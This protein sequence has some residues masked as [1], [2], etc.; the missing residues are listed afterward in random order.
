MNR[1]AARG[2]APKRRR[3]PNAYGLFATVGIVLVGALGGLMYAY[4]PL[5]PIFIYLAALTI[6]AFLLCGYDKKVAG[7][8]ATRV[9]E[10][11]L[12]AI[13]LLG[14]SAG[15]LIG[16]K[17]FRHKTRKVSFRIVVGVIL[18]LQ[19]VAVGWLVSRQL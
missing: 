11:V 14:G 15:L 19:A 13:A 10:I 1:S 8:E 17:T 12:F 6:V 4:T 18:A 7:R 2:S 16:M 3:A 5:P 9:P